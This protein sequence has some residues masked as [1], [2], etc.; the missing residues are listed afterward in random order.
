MEAAEPGLSASGRPQMADG[1]PFSGWHKLPPVREQGYCLLLVANV[2]GRTSQTR[3]AQKKD[4]AAAHAQSKPL[5]AGWRS[6]R[7]IRTANRTK[8]AINAM[9][10]M[11]N[12]GS[13]IIGAVLVLRGAR[14]AYP[15][16]R[17]TEGR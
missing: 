13:A 15:F 5:A 1:E 10:A 14:L 16:R 4:T 9:A 8:A 12:A 2:Q 3:A 17:P 7:L 11:L 6:R